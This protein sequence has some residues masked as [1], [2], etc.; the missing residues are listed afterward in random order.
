MSDSRHYPAVCKPSLPHPADAVR[1]RVVEPAPRLNQHVQAHQKPWRM[2]SPVVIDQALVDDKRAAHGSAACAFPISMRFV[3]R[4]Q[5][6]RIN[7]MIRTSACGRSSLKKSPGD[8]TQLVG[9]T[10]RGDIPGKDRFHRGQIKTAA[11]EMGVR[12]S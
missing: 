10:V 11:A 1:A 2:H 3:G 9:E 7:P 4:S 12:K 8:E 5:S 6:C